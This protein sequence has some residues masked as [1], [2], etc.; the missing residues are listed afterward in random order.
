MITENYIWE[1][2]QG[3]HDYHQVIRR[4]ENLN[5]QRAPGLEKHHIEPERVRVI[6]LKPL[7]HLA[8]H[9]AHA[10]VENTSSYYAKVGSFV[11]LFPGS[12][13]RILTVDSRLRQEL[14]SFGQK[15]PGNGVNLNQH[16]N[17]LAATK[18]PRTERQLA[19]SAETGRRTILVNSWHS[20]GIANTWGDKVSA[21]VRNKPMC[22]CLLCGREMKAIP[23]NIIQ[24][25]R[26]NKCSD[27]LKKA[28]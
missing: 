18:A 1:L 20:Q 24:H 4:I 10:Q 23:S 2:L 7:E 17:T 12:Y 22:C 26:S 16:P 11:H 9:I 6:Y 21:A 3:K 28:K 14:I 5:R 27:S 8:I 15:R 25:Q 13:R 19:A